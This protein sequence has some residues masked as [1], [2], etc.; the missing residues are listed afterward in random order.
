ML[1]KVHALSFALLISMLGDHVS[2]MASQSNTEVLSKGSVAHNER[3][4]QLTS[5]DC[6]TATTQDGDTVT[7]CKEVKRGKQVQY[8]IHGDTSLCYMV[9][10]MPCAASYLCAPSSQNAYIDCRNL[11]LNQ[12]QDCWS[13]DCS[14]NCLPE[15]D[16]APSFANG[17][18]DCKKIGYGCASFTA[19]GY[20]FEDCNYIDVLGDGKLVAVKT[21]GATGIPVSCWA[22]VD[23]T[24]C[25]CTADCDT[26]SGEISYDCSAL[27]SGPCAATKCGECTDKTSLTPGPEQRPS[28]SPPKPGTLGCRLVG[29]LAAALV[30]M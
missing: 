20:E 6:S 2:T 26:F 23:G 12:A 21:E 9:D 24:A 7:T 14:G 17:Q 25:N 18:N 19:S 8:A 13:V 4:L 16:Q 10:G 30:S 1:L 11:A 3:Q 22:K 29:I 5:G 28:I 15:T 27:S